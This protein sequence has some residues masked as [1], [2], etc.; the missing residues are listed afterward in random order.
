MP[1]SDTVVYPAAALGFAVGEERANA[2]HWG[3][4]DAAW[5]TVYVTLAIVAVPLRCGPVLASQDT[6]TTA[7]AVLDRRSQVA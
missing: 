5:L 2:E 4:G 1:V 7:D 3:V 6:V